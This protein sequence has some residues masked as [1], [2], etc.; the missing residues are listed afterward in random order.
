LSQKYQV[1][2]LVSV[3]S[4]LKF[5]HKGLKASP[6]MFQGVYFVGCVYKINTLNNHFTDNKSA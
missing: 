5:R 6:Y 1:H 3:C 4:P 2:L